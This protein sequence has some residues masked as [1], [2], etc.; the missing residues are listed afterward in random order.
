[1]VIPEILDQVRSRVGSDNLA[2]S[3]VREKCSISMVDI[4]SQ[5]VLIDV[6]RAFESLGKTQGKRCDYIL[7]F[8]STQDYLITVP[9]ELKRGTI[10]ASDVANQLAA[11]VN[12]AAEIAP[13]G[14][15]CFCVPLVVHGRSIDRHQRKILNERKIT[16]RKKRM[17]IKTTYCN[18][19]KNLANALSEWI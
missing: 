3:L 8:G 13:T 9:M 4:P 2:K 19:E 15:Q 11:G 1:M 17:S 14:V 16:F 12:F 5:H 7:F 6:D 10:H 18:K